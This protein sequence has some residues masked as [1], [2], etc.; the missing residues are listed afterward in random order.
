MLITV[1]VIMNRYLKLYSWMWNAFG[2]REFGIDEFRAVFP[3]PQPAKVMHD[4]I[5]LGYV[6][7][8]SRGNYTIVPPKKFAESMV[9]DNLK[10]IDVLKDAKKKYAYTDSDAVRIWTDDYYWTDFTAGFKPVHI[11]VLERDLEYWGRFFRERDVEFAVEGESKTLF[12]LSYIL[13]PEKNFKVEK[14]KEMPVI[15]LSEVV[16]FCRKNE[17]TYRPALEYLDKKFALKL[18]EEYEYI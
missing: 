4:L 1:I 18:F 16:E 3:C 2:N 11:K 17:L 7:G 15:P 6:K 5:R 12:G 8:V 9:E 10:Q 13:H 14:R